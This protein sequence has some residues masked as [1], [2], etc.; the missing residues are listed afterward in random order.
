MAHPSSHTVGPMRAAR[1]FVMAFGGARSDAFSGAAAR[2]ASGNRRWAMA[3]D[4]AI[5]MGLMGETPDAVDL[6]TITE[7]LAALESGG[8]CSRCPTAKR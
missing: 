2:L 6:D 7:R 1:D 5:I 4:N 3:P 8:C